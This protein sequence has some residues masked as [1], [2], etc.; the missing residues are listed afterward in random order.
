[1]AHAAAAGKGREYTARDR[2]LFPGPAFLVTSGA[3][4]LTSGGFVQPGGAGEEVGFHGQFAATVDR[5][6]AT[7]QPLAGGH[8]AGR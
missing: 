5:D 3:S 7:A 1:M 8:L 6:Q 4:P 2:L